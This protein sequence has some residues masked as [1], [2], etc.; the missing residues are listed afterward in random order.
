L[1][2]VGAVVAAAGATA[3]VTMRRRYAS[4]TAEAKDASDSSD[5]ERTSRI[6][7]SASD[8]AVRSDVNGRVTAPRE[9]GT[10]NTSRK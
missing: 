2:G 9:L 5:D 1:L 4:A 6:G 3:A 7:E 8:T 10:V